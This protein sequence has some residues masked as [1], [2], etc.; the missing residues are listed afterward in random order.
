MKTKQNLPIETYKSQILELVD[1]N[2]VIIICG[3]TGS[4]KTTQVPQYLLEHLEKLKE[5]SEE[6][7]STWLKEIEKDRGNYYNG[8]CVTQ[9]RRVAAITVANRVA[10]EQLRKVGVEFDEKADLIEKVERKVSYSIRFEDRC[11]S[12]TKLRYMTD[13]VLLRQLI[14]HSKKG[15]SRC[16]Y[17]CIILDE[18]HERSIFTD[19]L[20]GLL[21]LSLLKYPSLRVVIMSATLNIGKL[22]GYFGDCC[23]LTVEGRVFDVKVYHSQQKQSLLKT[24]Y[25]KKVGEVVGKICR[26]DEVGDILVFLTGREDVEFC[27]GMLRESL[28]ERVEVLPLYSS[29]PKQQQQ[30]VFSTHPTNIRRV[31]VATNIAETSLTLEH[32]AFVV[33]SGLEKIKH[34]SFQTGFSQLKI[35]PISQSSAEQRAGRA[36][37]V[38][39]GVCFRLYTQQEHSLLQKETLPEIKRV[40][41][42]ASVLQLLSM[43]LKDFDIFTFDFVDKPDKEAILFALKELFILGLVQRKKEKLELTKDGEICASIPLDP[44]LSKFVLVCKS[45]KVTLFGSI[46]ASFLS[47][48]TE[49]LFVKP[50]EKFADDEVEKRRLLEER[51]VKLLKYL[52]VEGDHLTFVNVYFNF[53]LKGR[54]SKRWCEENLINF[55]LVRNIERVSKQIFSLFSSRDFDEE[56]EKERRQFDSDDVVNAV[57]KS[58]VEVFYDKSAKSLFKKGLL[59]TSGKVICRMQKSCS[60]LKTNSSFEYIIYNEIVKSEE[61]LVLRNC[62]RVK[63]RWIEPLLLRLKTIDSLLEGKEETLKEEKPKPKAKVQQNSV[64]NA[65][66]RYLERKRVRE[67]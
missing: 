38:S 66:L 10:F 18:A 6:V 54:R 12:D 3:E 36:G 56:V 39:S 30:R 34:F 62:L 17:D 22:S 4:G 60:L 29:L 5:S 7:S 57:K 51:E 27:C 13:G 15:S 1:K 46:I 24:K 40:S 42:S 11:N 61:L 58:V 48:S 26:S 19:V 50:F 64:E 20:L 33:D 16:L 45:R 65:K 63:K 9:P 25:V 59:K 52:S 44:A 2:K 35:A 47:V 32:I 14:S 31:T 23:S 49:S 41:L 37:R 55:T 21:K 43:N 53:V 28:S 8:I 67:S